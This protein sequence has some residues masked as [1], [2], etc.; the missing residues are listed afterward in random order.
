MPVLVYVAMVFGGQIDH[1]VIDTRGS[2]E[3][4]I[5]IAIVIAAV[6]I[7]VKLWRRRKRIAARLAAAPE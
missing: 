6:I 5:L 4:G 2:T 1:V 3:H 7:G